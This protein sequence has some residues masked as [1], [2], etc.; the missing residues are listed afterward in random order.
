MMFKPLD[1]ML[2][3]VERYGVDSDSALF[4]ELLYTGEFVVKLTTAA[5]VSA[6][7][8]D[9]EYHRYR[10]LHGLVRADSLGDWVR[11]LDEALIGTGA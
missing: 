9:R 8:D 5:F 7:E 2:D 10:L 6:I 3:R 4:V 11:I 1:L